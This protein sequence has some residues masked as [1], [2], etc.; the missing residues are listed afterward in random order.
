MTAVVVVQEA[1]QQLAAI[2]AWWVANRQPTPALVIDAVQEMQVAPGGR[3][4]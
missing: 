4:G 3:D 1:E 2:L